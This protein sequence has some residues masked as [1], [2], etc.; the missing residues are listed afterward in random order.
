MLPE[1]EGEGKAMVWAAPQRASL[2]TRSFV[3]SFS[4]SLAGG[5]LGEVSGEGSVDYSSLFQVCCFRV[6]ASTDGSGP[7]PGP[8]QGVLVTAVGP[9]AA[10]LVLLLFWAWR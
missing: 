8:G 4:L 1:R 7:G 2:R 5:T 9:G 6:L 3:L 10:C